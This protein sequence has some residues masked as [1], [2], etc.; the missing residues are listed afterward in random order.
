MKQVERS[1]VLQMNRV[2]NISKQ[3]QRAT[4]WPINKAGY[5][6]N[7]SRGWLGRGK[8]AHFRTFSTRSP[9]RTNRVC[10]YA[11]GLLISS[12]S[13]GSMKTL[14]SRHSL[15]LFF[16]IS[17]IFR[18]FSACK[19]CQIYIYF[20]RLHPVLLKIRLINHFQ[21][22]VFSITKSSCIKAEDFPC[23]Q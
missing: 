12:S 13:S 14:I 3:T 7:T 17:I 16:S 10:Q 20:Q 18:F 11:K 6:A 22:Y 5:T 21:N 15:F 2:S 23:Y 8:N 4:E 1:G 19:D 9:L